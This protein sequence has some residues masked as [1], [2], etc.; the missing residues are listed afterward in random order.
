MT[1]DRPPLVGV[2]CGLFPEG[3]DGRA[4]H[5]AAAVAYFHALERA[6]AAAVALA[7]VSDPQRL[8]D[9]VHG[10]LLTGGTDVDPARYGEARGRSTQE[11]D[12]VRDRFEADAI[13]AA[14]GRGLPILGICRG[15][16]VLNVALGGTLVQDIPSEVPQA[17]RHDVQPEQRPAHRVK[18][19]S[20][21]R[22]A[23]IIG[24]AE[25]EVNSA[26]HQ[27]IRRVGE[28]LRAAAL[29]P[30]GLV[31]AVESTG[32]GWVIGVQWHPEALAEQA[33]AHQA[34]FDALVQAAASRREGSTLVS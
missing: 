19:E 21:S 4:L 24:G 11:S 1:A 16:Q 29:S 9:H 28:G 2:V 7:P 20:D 5:A 13:Q 30:D 26:H 22:L 18:V 25:L 33:P 34:I 12:P 8:L 14:L 15:A 3:P 27:A 31:E 10:L 23:R 32:H 6:G 17:C